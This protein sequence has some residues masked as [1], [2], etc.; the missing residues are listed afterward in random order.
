MVTSGKKVAIDYVLTVDGQKFDSSEKAGPL[1]YVHGQ[2]QIIPGLEKELE[3]MAIGS[4]K[5]VQITPENGYGPINPEAFK[6]VPKTAI[7]DNLPIEAG[8]ILN[9]T[10]PEGKSF[11][12]IIAEIKEE[13]LLLNLNH[14]LAGKDLTF[15]VTV[16][17][18]GE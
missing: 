14:P 13:S 5:I 18:V 8:K 11:P 16:V 2:G 17:S 10:T 3:G 4:Q 7:P 9:I 1:E 15:D 12:A 6:E